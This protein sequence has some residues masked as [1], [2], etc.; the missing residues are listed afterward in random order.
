MNRTVANSLAGFVL[1][2]FCTAAFS[3]DS[4]EVHAKLRLADG[5]TTYRIGEPIR[6]VLELTA[7]REGYNADRTA[8]SHERP[9]DAISVSPNTA[10]HQW[11]EEYL[12]GSYGYRD[13]F[14]RVALTTSPTAIEFLLNDSIRF[15]HPGRYTVRVTTRRVSPNSVANQH[16]PAIT[17]TT[18]EVTIDIVSMSDAEEEKEI[19]R[20]ADL[21]DSARGWQAE[22]AAGRLLSYLTGD[23]SSREKVRRLFADGNRSSNYQAQIYYGLYIAR[24]RALVLQLLEAA[25][26]D[27]NIPLTTQV[28]GVLTQLRLLRE[29]A[30]TPAG[31]KPSMSGQGPPADPRFIEIRDGYV[32]DLSVGLDKRSGKSQT[33]T[34]TTILMNL[35]KD[36]QSAKAVSAQVRRILL[37]QFDTLHPFDQEYLLS[38]KWDELRDPSLI[39]SLKKM[40]GS[41]GGANKDSHRFALERLLDLS[42]EEARPYVIA[43]IRTPGSNVDPEILGRLPDKTLPEVDAALLYQ[44]RQFT[45][46]PNPLFEIFLQ[47]KTALAAR[48]ASKAIYAD[49]MDVYR[50]VGDKMPQALPGFLAYF[51]RHDEAEGLALLEQ[52]LERFRGKQS[53]LFHNF[54]RLYFS[55]AVDALLRKRLESDEQEVAST[56][57]YLISQHGPADDQK[58]IE[59]RLQR[60]QKEWSPRIAEADSNLQGRVESELIMALTR[61]KAWKLPAERIKEIQQS[62]LTKICKQ[63]FHV[64]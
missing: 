3:Q 28:L 36:S 38:T 11:L 50:N 53:T 48:F 33:T 2:L 16:K 8:D 45:S 30:D 43:E 62:C 14:S 4:L 63:N 46:A 15:D 35:P 22:E 9:T 10:A 32:T 20:I 60:W 1:V 51:A 23:V 25:M 61:Q 57:A 6:L 41:T 42:P 39:P 54:T 13:Y 64:Q 26:R 29:R 55:E 59:Q 19:K 27:P 37:S 17:L 40:L 24:N 18:N 5:K 21:I 56:A 52:T 49:M 7:D 31:P 58:V 34:A 44:I 47:L 12:T